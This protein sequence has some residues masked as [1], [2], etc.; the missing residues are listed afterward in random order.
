MIT[1]EKFEKEKCI[2]SLDELINFLEKN[3]DFAFSFDELLNKSN[4]DYKTLEKTLSKKVTDKIIDVKKIKGCV[5]IIY[6][7]NYKKRNKK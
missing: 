7:K 2:N 5:Y 6:N 4:V 1:R 3:K